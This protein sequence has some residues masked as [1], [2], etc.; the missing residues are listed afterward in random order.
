MPV[1][2]HGAGADWDEAL[3]LALGLIVAAAVTTMMVWHRGK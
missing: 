3:L 1:W 2:L